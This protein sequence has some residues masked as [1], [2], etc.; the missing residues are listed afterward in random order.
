MIVVL[1]FFVDVARCDSA[2][3]SDELFRILIYAATLGSGG[4]AACN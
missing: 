3:R 4:L 1:V 2:L